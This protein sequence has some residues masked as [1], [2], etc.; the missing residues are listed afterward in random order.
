MEEKNEAPDF[1]AKDLLNPPFAVPL[2]LAVGIVTWVFLK[3]YLG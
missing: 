2:L 1:S 3:P